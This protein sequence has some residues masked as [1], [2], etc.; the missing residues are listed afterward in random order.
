MI[1]NTGYTGPAEVD[2]EKAGAANWRMDFRV[3]RQNHR[4]S[5][6]A[7]RCGESWLP[8]KALFYPCQRL[9]VS[10][11]FPRCL[12]FLARKAWQYCGKISLK[13]KR[14]GLDGGG[15]HML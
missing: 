1:G 13:P 12:R 10:Q 15:D 9:A 8:Q 3:K 4:L 11:Q 7:A 5:S 14:L 2:L 6:L